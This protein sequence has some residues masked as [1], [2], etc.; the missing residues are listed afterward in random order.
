MI[1]LA[2]DR[3]P[4]GPGGASRSGTPMTRILVVSDDGAVT[5]DVHRDD[6]GWTSGVCRACRAV[7]SNR[8]QFENFLHAFEVHVDQQ[9]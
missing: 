9:H 2:D 7:I 3:K 5:V 8:G 6:E 1:G 4:R